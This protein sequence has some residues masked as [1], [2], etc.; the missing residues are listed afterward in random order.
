MLRAA[1]ASH[2][3]ALVVL[4]PRAH[5]PAGHSMTPA[6][7][8]ELATVL[9]RSRAVVVEDD[10]AA[11]IS[12]AE[13]I[14]LGAALPERTVHIRGFAKSHGPDLRL[15]AIG[16]A[17][18]VVDRVVRR[19]LL[20]PAWSSRLL[21]SVLVDLL[22]DPASVAAVERART[23]YANRRAALIGTLAERGIQVS[24]DDGINVWVSVRDER[25]ALVSLA[26]HGV[27][28]APGSPFLTGPLSTDHVRITCASLRECTGR[29]A[30]LIADADAPDQARRRAV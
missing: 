11:Y 15:A 22:T 20:G 25:S 3:P 4:Q 24:G 13:P 27:T 28:V 10:H 5:N 23:A 18:D 7:T 17:P 14:S 21:Q 6:R 9:R 1:V 16:G 8:A 19:R 2:D 30:E 12:T 26:V 29:L